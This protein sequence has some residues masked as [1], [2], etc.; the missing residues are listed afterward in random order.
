MKK[1]FSTELHI[2][3]YLYNSFIIYNINFFLI[4]VIKQSRGQ[5]INPIKSY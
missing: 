4:K 2:L 5:K 3:K 1:D